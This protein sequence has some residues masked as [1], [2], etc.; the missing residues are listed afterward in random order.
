M[1]NMPRD[2]AGAGGLADFDGGEALAGGQLRTPLLLEVAAEGLVF[3]GAVVGEVH[4]DGADVAGALD[5]V[6]AA[7]G[8]EAGAAAAN[9]AG[10]EGEVDESE[11]GLGAVRVL[12]DAE[13]PVEGGLVGVAD[14]VGGAFEGGGGNAGEGFLAFGGPV[15][16]GGGD[17]LEVLDAAG[18]EVFVD[19]AV[20]DDDVEQGVVHGDV[21]AGA[22]L[23]VDV[24]PSG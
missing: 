10:G 13:A 14:D 12:G 4:G 22:A 9:V 11:A 23:E 17:G 16:D 6:L 8:V 21:G 15:A 1:M 2:I 5:V 19:E 24:G 3:D 20:A 18:D 7:E